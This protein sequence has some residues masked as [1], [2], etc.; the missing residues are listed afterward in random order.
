MVKLPAASSHGNTMK[1][2][3]KAFC[4]RNALPLSGH[5]SMKYRPSETVA[6]VNQPAD[7]RLY[8]TATDRR[9]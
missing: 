6:R 1:L 5:R 2:Y 3:R 4:L 8:R 7:E 9:Q